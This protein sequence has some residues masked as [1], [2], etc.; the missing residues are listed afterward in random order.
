MS[1]GVLFALVAA[2]FAAANLFCIIFFYQKPAQALTKVCIMPLLAVY[3][4][5][6]AGIF[7]PAALAAALF[8]WLGD[9]FLVKRR[10]VAVIVC[11]IAAFFAG[12]LCYAASILRF[13]D[14][15]GAD[16][17]RIAAAIAVIAVVLVFMFVRTRH[18]LDAAA[19]LY[20]LALTGL[21]V[22]AAAL[23]VQRKDSAAAAI[24][25]GALCLIVSDICLAAGYRGNAGRLSN[26]AVMILYIAA[27]FC[28][29][30]GLSAL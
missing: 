4:A 29:L 2:V 3:Y 12:N 11:G 18:I 22:C 17:I 10:G 14:F 16:G 27:Q 5:L 13:V 7:L 8:C 24:L 1:A 15:P 30:S 23:L 26:F 21:A 25:A 19:A 28:L 20:G 9:I 6:S